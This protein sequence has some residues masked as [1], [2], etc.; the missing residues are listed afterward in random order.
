M[1]PDSKQAWVETGYRLFS[2]EGPKGLKVE[3]IARNVNKSKSSFYHHFADLE[4]FTGLLLEHH[5]VRSKTIAEEEKK[6]RNIDPELISVLVA[7][8]T[9]LLFNRQLRVHRTD[10]TFKKCLQKSDEIVSQGFISVLT[11]DLRLENN[12]KLAASLFDLALENFYLQV[13]EETLNGEWLSAYF[14][15]LKKT[16]SQF[17]ISQ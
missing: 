5:L 13:T 2:K 17:N 1:A 8:K 3:V 16:V 12:P 11:K 6:C 15:N 14:T 10:P 9:D 4:I 7:S